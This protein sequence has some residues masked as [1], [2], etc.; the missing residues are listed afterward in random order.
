MPVWV[1][2]RRG[3]KQT[4]LADAESCILLPS[5]RPSDSLIWVYFLQILDK[6]IIGYSTVFGL[7][8]DAGL[9]GDQVSG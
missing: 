2:V 4:T 3:S 6:S 5:I 9:V 8:T 1:I 7:K